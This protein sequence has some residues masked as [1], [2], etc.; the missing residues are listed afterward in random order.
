MLI[1]EDE[2]T[3]RRVPKEGRTDREESR[4]EA[5]GTWPMSG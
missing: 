1:G 3:M 2:Y 5:R 4:E